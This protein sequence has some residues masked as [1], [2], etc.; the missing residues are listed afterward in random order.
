M[1]SKSKTG[2]SAAKAKP[3]SQDKSPISNQTVDELA[4]V[5]EQLIEQIVVLRQAID[6]IGVDLQWALRKHVVEPHPVPSITSMPSNPLADD[7]ADKLNTVP[8]EIV[9]RLRAEAV[10]EAALQRQPKQ[11]CLW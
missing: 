1:T 6:E 10:Q 2:K 11:A 5:V 8:P 7:F 4:Y 3:T 9:E